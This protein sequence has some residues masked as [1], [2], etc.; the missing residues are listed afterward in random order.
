[1][2]QLLLFRDLQAWEYMNHILASV[3]YHS[4]PKFPVVSIKGDIYFTISLF[5]SSCYYRI[6]LRLSIISAVGI[7]KRHKSFSQLAWTG[8]AARVRYKGIDWNI[9]VV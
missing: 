4:N 9:Y 7:Y 3:R 1:M 2:K 6:W 5:Y 8:F